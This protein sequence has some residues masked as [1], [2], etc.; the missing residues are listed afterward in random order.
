MSARSTRRKLGERIRNFH[1]TLKGGASSMIRTL[2]LIGYWASERHPEWPDPRTFIESAWDEVERD[3]V[4]SHL[5]RGFVA[6]AYM[7]LSPC[8]LCDERVGSL[9][10]SDGEFIW[11]EGLDHYVEAHGLRPP[12]G[13]ITHVLEWTD[14][15][16][17]AAV[18]STWWQSQ[19]GSAPTSSVD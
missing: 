3:L 7:G 9:E 18:D 16:E 5:R 6:R 1:A 15:L 10:L 19:A 8:R 13:F 11:P 4:L 14:S 12:R 17:E 2:T